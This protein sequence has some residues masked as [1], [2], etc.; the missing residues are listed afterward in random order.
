[1]C[2]GDSSQRSLGVRRRKKGEDALKVDCQSDHCLGE[3]RRSKDHL[4]SGDETYKPRNVTK[5]RKKEDR[6]EKSRRTET[7]LSEHLSKGIL[8]LN[9]VIANSTFPRKNFLS[10]ADHQKKVK[11]KPTWVC[12][13]RKNRNERSPARAKQL[14]FGALSTKEGGNYGYDTKSEGTKRFIKRTRQ[15]TKRD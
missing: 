11:E 14:G 5:K 13:G 1:M 6:P 3:E 2:R 10:E 12:L 7:S 9:R 15:L 4:A 8:W